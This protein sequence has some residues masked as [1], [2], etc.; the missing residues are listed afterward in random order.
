MSRVAVNTAEARAEL[1][2]VMQVRMDAVHDLTRP[3][4]M[5]PALYEELNTNFKLLRAL[6]SL[7]RPER[8]I[9]GR[10]WGPRLA[11]V[12]CTEEKWMILIGTTII[13]GE[14]V[15]VDGMVTLDDNKVW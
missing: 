1:I 13:D 3:P 5:D 9:L 11:M 4:G 14:D 6:D 12:E 10:V 15:A 8:T 2:R 7:P